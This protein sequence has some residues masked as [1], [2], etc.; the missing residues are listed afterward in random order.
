MSEAAGGSDAAASSGGG[1]GAMSAGSTGAM[2]A[3]SLIQAG[4]ALYAGQAQSASL[5]AQAA[6]QRQNAEQDLAAGMLNASRIQAFGATKLGAIEGGAAAG[7]VTESGSVLNVM[8][9]STMNTEMDRQNTLHGA[10]LKATN[11]ENQASMD[12]LGA[13]SAL[14]GSYWSAAGSL[15]SG[16]GMIAAAALM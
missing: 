13:K 2:G 9:A 10:E 1:S 6:L 11:A 3:G 8:A 15:V 12:E 14:Q 4:G 16:G 5:D 7:G